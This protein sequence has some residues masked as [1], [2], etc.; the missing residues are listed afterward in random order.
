MEAILSA[1]AL[2]G[3]IMLRPDELGKVAPGYFADLIL[4]DGD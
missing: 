1:T 3:Q 4:L 2:G